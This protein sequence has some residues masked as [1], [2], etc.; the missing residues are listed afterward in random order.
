MTGPVPGVVSIPEHVLIQRVHTGEAVILNLDDESY[1]GLNEV[2]VRMMDMLVSSETLDAAVESL[3]SEYEVDPAVLR[4]DVEEL[5]E[6][7]RSRGLI[8]VT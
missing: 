2:G 4:R 3:V 5:V 7:L 6:T 1:F 8:D